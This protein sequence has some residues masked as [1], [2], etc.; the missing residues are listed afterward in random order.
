M[1]RRR[2]KDRELNI[3]YG[4]EP[5]V[6][7]RWL[8]HPKERPATMTMQQ[9]IQLLSYDIKHS[10]SAD[11][12]QHA[13]EELRKYHEETEKDNEAHRRDPEAWNRDW[14]AKYVRQ[15]NSRSS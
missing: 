14:A 3:D 13:V 7:E 4:F 15:L 12:K 8:T 2:K 9:F 1:A 11:D 6:P 10:W 5:P